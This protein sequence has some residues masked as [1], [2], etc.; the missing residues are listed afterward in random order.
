MKKVLITGAGSRLTRRDFVHVSLWHLLRL[1]ISEIQ[2]L[3][4]T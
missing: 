4:G 2:Y 3:P 1:F